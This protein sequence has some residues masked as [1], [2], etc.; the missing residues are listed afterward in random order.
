L[1]AWI[2]GRLVL[3][4]TQLGPYFSRPI[5]YF[6]SLAPVYLVLLAAVAALV[7]VTLWAIRRPAFAAMVRRWL[8]LALIV[9]TVVSGI[10]ALYFRAPGGHLAAHD[11]HSVRIFVYLYF[12]PIAFGLA[13][14]GYA[15]VVWRSF[16]RAPA[17]ILTITTLAFL[18]LYKMRIWPEHFWLARRFI[19]AILPGALIFAVAALRRCEGSRRQA[20]VPARRPLD[21]G[22]RRHRVVPRSALSDEL[23]PYPHA[24]R[25]AGL[26]P[27]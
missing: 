5:E 20:M 23:R 1:A 4:T 8:P 25:H 27:D 19:P 12:T 2:A 18:F 9:A 10:Y 6:N 16:W 14:A 7:C 22:R 11:A 13:L 15:L 26:I 24:H 3:H 21:S 17:L